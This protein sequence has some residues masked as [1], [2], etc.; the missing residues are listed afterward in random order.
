MAEFVAKFFWRIIIVVEYALGGSS[1]ESSVLD[2][3]L[4]GL[5]LFIVACL[6]GLLLRL[7]NRLFELFKKKFFKNSSDQKGKKNEEPA[8][9]PTGSI[10]A[11]KAT[12]DRS[13]PALSRKFFYEIK[14]RI[15]IRKRKK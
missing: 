10:C 11:T 9:G 4:G 2:V 13:Y 15:R 14:K 12:S 6:L 8:N 1:S 3:Y 7:F 5:N